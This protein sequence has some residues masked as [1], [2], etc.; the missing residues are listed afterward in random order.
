M[1]IVYPTGFYSINSNG[2]SLCVIWY[3][4]TLYSTDTPGIYKAWH[5]VSTS[6][7]IYY[8]YYHYIMD[9]CVCWCTHFSEAH[10]AITKLN[11]CILSACLLRTGLGMLYTLISPLSEN[12]CIPMRHLPLTHVRT[13]T[14]CIMYIVFWFHIIKPWL[15]KIVQLR[16]EIYF[17]VPFI[18]HVLNASSSSHDEYH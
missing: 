7:H 3:R 8:I 4:F 2:N 14:Y 10:V 18:R 6:N 5:R 1:E 9:V 15:A 12:V 16:N 13:L 17:L 11:F